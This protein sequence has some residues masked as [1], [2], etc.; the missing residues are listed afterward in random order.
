M[1]IVGEGALGLETLAILITDGYQKPVVFY[2]DNATKA[3]SLYGHKVITDEKEL[4]QYLS[5]DN[6]FIVSIGHPRL[7]AKKYQKLLDLGG[8]PVNVVSKK[9]H[10]F[11]ML[12]QFDGCIIEPSAGISHGV[13]MGKGCAIHI[14][15]TVGHQVELGNFVNVG[16]GANVVGPCKIGDYSYISV[17]AVVHPHVTI[18]QYAFIGSN[19]VVNRDVADYETYLG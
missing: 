3:G 19:V 5:E 10:I 4:I 6:E 9:A 15:C 18:G 2:D 11:P 13:K 14:N 8:I 17:G 7:R 16:P 12:N 1:I